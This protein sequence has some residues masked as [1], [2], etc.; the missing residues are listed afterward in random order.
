M[1]PL[2]ARAARAGLTGGSCADHWQFAI[3]NMMEQAAPLLPVAHADPTGPAV[4]A[5]NVRAPCQ[6]AALPPHTQLG[7][8]V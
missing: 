7:D 6:A 2:G 1:V 8:T 5:L 3:S 4:A